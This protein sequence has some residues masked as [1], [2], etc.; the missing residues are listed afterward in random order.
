[1]SGTAE[2]LGALGLTLPIPAPSIAAYVPFVRAGGLL[3]VSGQLAFG[4]MGSIAPEHI[5][6]LGRDVGEAAGREA[7]RR[8][9]LNVLAQTQA[10]L[11]DLDRIMRCVRLGGF[12]KCAPDFAALAAVMN[13]ASDLMIE[14]L[15]ER[16]RHARS[17]IGV[18]QLPLG[19]VVEV[20]ATF[21]IAA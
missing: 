12:I 20:E 5:G 16:G 17:T 14:V 11:G 4:P 8:C 7:A 15:G 3:F 18:A 10:A 9:A 19:C 2:R 21:E 13:G 6:A 1:M